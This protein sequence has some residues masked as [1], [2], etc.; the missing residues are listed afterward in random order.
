MSQL[1]TAPQKIE[2][3]NSDSKK[4]TDAE[5]LETQLPLDDL[6]ALSRQVQAIRCGKYC[7]E[8]EE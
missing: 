4:L 7:E 2:V 3:L 8:Y 5:I 6:D 1:I